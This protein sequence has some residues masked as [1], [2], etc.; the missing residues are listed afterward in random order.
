[1]EETRGA[2]IVGV[3]INVLG[4]GSELPCNT[5]ATT[6]EEV[7]L[8][9]GTGPL[10]SRE[11]LLAAILNRLHEHYRNLVLGDKESVAVIIGAADELKG[12]KVTVKVPGGEV[13][14]VGSGVDAHGRLCLDTPSGR[15]CIVAGEVVAID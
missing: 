1:V 5:A 11:A 4:P 3:G 2:Y 13:L 6:V 8:C 15:V 9:D 12:R 14:G 10:P 7:A